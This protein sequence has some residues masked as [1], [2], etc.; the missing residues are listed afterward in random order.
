MFE[1]LSVTC[2]RPQAFERIDIC[3]AYFGRLCFFTSLSATEVT[4]RTKYQSFLK[5]ESSSS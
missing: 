1:T 4:E 2:E 3:Y 5:Y